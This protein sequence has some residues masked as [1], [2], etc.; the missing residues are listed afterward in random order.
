MNTPDRDD[1]FRLTGDDPMIEQ[2]ERVKARAAHEA[3]AAGKPN[4]TAT[5]TDSDKVVGAGGVVP[6]D[7]FEP[8]ASQ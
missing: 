8:D 2:V 4:S 1:D 3:A 6:A 7:P 5:D